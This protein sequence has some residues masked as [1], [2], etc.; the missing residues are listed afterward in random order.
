MLFRSENMSLD[1]WFIFGNGSTPNISD[2]GNRMLRQIT[3]DEIVKMRNSGNGSVD[4]DELKKRVAA[5]A[6][7]RMVINGGQLMPMREVPNNVIPI[8]NHVR[9]PSGIFE[10]TVGNMNKAVD[11]IPDGLRNLVIPGTGTDIIEDGD[12]IDVSYNTHYALQGANLYAVTSNGVSVNLPIGKEMKGNL[13]YR[14][15]GQPYAFYQL[16]DNNER[17]FTLTG[18]IVSDEM[19]LKRYVNP[20]IRLIPDSATNPSFYRLAVEPHFLKVD[21]DTMMETELQALAESS[22]WQPSQNTSF[23]YDPDMVYP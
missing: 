20:A 9:N 22:N 13:Q 18:N 10:D 23:T 6:S 2:A 8:G 17:R 1:G 11:S 14:E 4:P 7:S 19:I 5:L 16:E 21:G 15:D 3:E 12:D